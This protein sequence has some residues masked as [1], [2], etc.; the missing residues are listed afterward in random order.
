MSIAPLYKVLMVGIIFVEFELMKLTDEFTGISLY[1]KC[2][3]P[4]W[5][6]LKLYVS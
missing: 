1:V 4:F 5:V 3:I 6:I 2:R